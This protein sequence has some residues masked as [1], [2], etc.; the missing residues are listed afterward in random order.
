MIYK[1]LCFI[2]LLTTIILF[3]LAASAG[4]ID[5]DLDGSQ[6][7][8]GE[9]IGWINF[10]PS[11]GPGVTVSS[12]NLTGY[13][14]GENI[15]WINLSPAFGGVNNDGLGNLSGYAWGENA[16][17]I[18][19]APAGGGVDINPYTGVFSGKAWGENIGWISFDSSGP[20]SFRVKTSWVAEYTLTVSKS[21]TG[22]G[23]VTSGLWGINCGV[24]CSYNYSIG[25]LVTLSAAPNPGSV[26]AGWSGGGCSGTGSCVI[27]MNTNIAVTATFAAV[28]PVYRFWS[29]T[30][31]HHFYTISEFERDYVIAT[32]PTVWTY[33]GPVFYAFTTQVPGTLPVYRF[34]SSTYRGHFYTISEFE[35][36]YVIATWPETWTFEGPAFYA[37]ST[38]VPGTSPV[39]RF[40]SNV[41]LGHFYTISQIERDYVIAT[42]PTAWSYEGPVYYTYPIP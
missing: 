6:Y 18:N 20:V 23:T 1:L 5:P 13:A 28:S 42:W 15:G 29:N 36:D 10:E 35:R 7:A 22:S 37:F 4:N 25:T 2:F 41:F 40:W 17:W 31:L 3:P 32:W 14:W 21:G 39:Y 19:F 26:F 33:E 24:G 27:T 34:W 11:H 9:N 38:Q 30:Y 12:T 16:G 8:Y